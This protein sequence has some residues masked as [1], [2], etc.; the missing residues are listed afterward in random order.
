MILYCQG[1][2]LAAPEPYL[3][4]EVMQFNSSSIQ[5]L[6]NYSESD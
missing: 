2:Q 5:L 4:G 6:T 1:D 3:E